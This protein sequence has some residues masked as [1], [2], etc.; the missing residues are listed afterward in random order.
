[1]NRSNF[2]KYMAYVKEQKHVSI[3]DYYI[4]KDYF[5]SFFLSTWQKLKEEGKTPHL[6]TLVFKGGTLLGR[7]ILQ[8]SRISEDLDFTYGDSNDLRA[9]K[10]KGKRETEIRKSVIPIIDEIKLICDAIQL[11]FETDRTNTRYI[12]ARNS[13]A[14]YVFNMYYVSL[15]TGEQIPIKIE[16][17]FLEHIIHNCS[18]LRINNIVDPDLYLKSIDYDLVNRVM[19]TYSL[20]EIILE[21]YRAILTRGA[22][23]ERDILD[24]YFIHQKGTD[25]FK[26]DNQLIFNKIKSGVLISPDLLEN[27]KK[28][29]QL[30]QD[31]A[32]GESDDD[33]HR[34]TLVEID[35]EG[36]EK[37]K[38]ILYE[39]LKKI[40]KMRKI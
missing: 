11:D 23:K 40:C 21:K 32:F 33:I 28:N 16:V 29:C 22:L 12:V 6:D 19:N 35:D 25:V 20:E 3:E 15:L 14:I 30:L 9:I 39:K 8:Y 34:L 31:G 7:N 2:R 37:F 24:L 10:S 13:R 17:N 27:L 1:M 38:D 36:Y 5:L 18:E 26:A 4:E